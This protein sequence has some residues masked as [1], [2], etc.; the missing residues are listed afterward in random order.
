MTAR[1]ARLRLTRSQILDFRRH[2]QGLDARRRLRPKTL[3]QAAWAGLQDSMPRAAL[4]SLH[5]RLAGTNSTS[6]AT[7]SLVQVWGTRYSAYVVHARDAPLF[8]LARLPVGGPTR[9]VA[10]DLA[11]RLARLLGD[12]RLTQGAA[13]AALGEPPNRLRYA[14]L[15]GRVRIRWDGAKQPTIWLVSPPEVDAAQARLELARRYLHIFGPAR[16]SDGC[17]A[18]IQPKLLSS[19]DGPYR[20]GTVAP[21]KRR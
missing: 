1:T 10:E 17:P 14:T 20:A 3:Q 9:R 12:E 5:A 6:W 19:A 21:I 18:L 2:T 8:A 13:A 4:L 15:T 16:T 7:P 11:D